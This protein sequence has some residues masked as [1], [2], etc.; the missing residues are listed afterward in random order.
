L[1]IKH[2]VRVRDRPL[3]VSLPSASL[4]VGLAAFVA[5]LARNRAA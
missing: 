2:S 5:K 1:S 4:P 3:P